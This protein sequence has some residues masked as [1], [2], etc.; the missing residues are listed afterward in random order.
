MPTNV[1]VSRWAM[2]LLVALAWFC[3]S[4]RAASALDTYSADLHTMFPDM[5]RIGETD[6]SP[7]AAVI[8][9]AQGTIG[10]ALLTADILPIPAYSGKPINTL[11]AFDVAGRIRGVRIVAHEEPILVVGISEQDLAR[12]VAQYVGQPI[13]DEI[14]IGGRAAPGRSVVDGISGATI[15][16]MVV[17]RTIV[18]SVR[19][20]ALARG[21]LV[22]DGGS[23]RF[24]PPAPLWVIL[25]RD[26]VW[27]IV[28]LGVGLGMLLL[29]L[30][31]QDW[32]ARHPTFLIRVRTLYLLFTLLFIGAYGYAQL[33]VV[34]VLTFVS[35]LLG[36][37]RWESF[38]I[39]P[40]M[41][42]LWS[43]VAVTIVLWGRGVYCGWLCPF[44]A[45]QELL[46]RLGQRL[47]IKG[48]EL[49]TVVHERLLALKYLLLLGLF[50]LSL[51]SLATAERFAEVEPF[52]TVFALRFMREWP[53]VVYALVLLAIGL[54]IRKA[55]C[56]YLCPLGAALT[57]PSRFRIFDWLR[58]RKE[59]GRPCQTCA[60]ECE[61]QAIRP[62]GEIVETECH[63]CL[64]CQ[65]T[66]WDDRR[67]P[68]LVD[69][70]KKAELKARLARD[71]PV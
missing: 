3:P 35:S 41:F 13:A 27:E 17:N 19:K 67:C 40:M 10:Y 9:G 59:C 21:L 71:K 62:T 49:P 4:L 2:A 23:R 32:L 5:Q 50:A 46:Y 38:L 29:I 25:W 57:F 61:V 14:R 42:M 16:A 18:E 60:R 24:E 56:R 36:G 47:G 64:D 52:K 69:R 53:F 51:Q 6:G 22:Q 70:R 68:P 65:V 66:Y 34:N 26:R 8:Y 11:V 7:P 48:R 63:Y 58:R 37:F 39:E 30:L 44:G 33:S 20:V 15:T 12:Y 55:F 45:L 1:T 31:F 43:F 54:F 28:V